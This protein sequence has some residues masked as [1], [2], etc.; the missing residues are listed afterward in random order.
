MTGGPDEVG[1]EVVQI[2]V[3]EGMQN[4]DPKSQ[5]PQNPQHHGIGNCCVEAHVDP[6]ELADSDDGELFAVRIPV[7]F[8]TA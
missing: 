3:P 8:S 5:D 4:L 1:D 7:V 2:S 6:Y